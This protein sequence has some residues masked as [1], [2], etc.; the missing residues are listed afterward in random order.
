M[1]RKK[2]LI[3]LPWL[4]FPITT[5]GHQALF[6]G[7]KAIASSFDIYL[8]FE[9]WDDK[10]YHSNAHQFLQMFPNVHLLPLLH[11][12]NAYKKPNNFK[13]FSYKAKVLIWNLIHKKSTTNSAKGNP[14]SKIVHKW[15]C[16]IKPQSEIWQKHINEI[17]NQHH[18]D[19]IQVEMPWFISFVLNLPKDPIKIYV[20]HE[21]GFVKREL[22]KNSLAYNEY[23]NTYKKYIDL[24]EI[25]LLNQYDCV[26][27]LSKI[28]AIK[29]KEKGVDKPIF[30]SFAAIENT[31]A[32][33]YQVCD[34]KQ[35]V[36]VGPEHTPN[37]IGL[38]WFLDNCWGKLQE[39]D[40]RYNL[41]IIG[42]W[43]K[44]HIDEYEMKYSNIHFMG[45]VE[46][47][48]R[49]LKGTIM[50]VPI[51]IGSGI[52]IK[53]LE[54]CSLGIPFVSTSVGAEGIPVQNEVNCFIADDAKS[55]VESIIKLQYGEI[56]KKYVYNSKKMVTE[57]FSLD[58]LRNNR[59]SIYNTMLEGKQQYLI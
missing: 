18:F 52:R 36:F 11:I 56:Q 51:T 54:A 14:L 40:S 39:R 49:E 30:S 19:F 31:T 47:L 41:K 58:A 16:N 32:T 24:I 37:L 44:K 7:I 4:P 42:K 50:I 57:E 15:E 46:N 20:H 5:G 8:A 59:T 43:S 35:L 21:L 28:D 45:Y 38:T 33:N 17:V 29:L 27:S 13:S 48:E 3:I 9:A 23:V 6:S 34:G 1:D 22:E 55:F 2:I 12:K 10:E 25:S 26:I 53:I